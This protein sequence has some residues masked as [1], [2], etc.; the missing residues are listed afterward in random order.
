MYKYFTLDEF[1]SPDE[2]GSGSNMNKEFMQL[3]DLA[4]GI[5]GISFK[6]N[7]GYRTAAR[8]K[9]AGG[10]SGSS[11]LKGLAADIA[12]NNSKERYI[13]LQALLKAGFNRIGVSRSFIHVDLDKTKA[14]CVIWT[15]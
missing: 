5:A 2:K 1:D 3:L 4:R 14:S 10:V 9:K 6:I 13:I 15:Y 12:V 8:N 7:S 11:H